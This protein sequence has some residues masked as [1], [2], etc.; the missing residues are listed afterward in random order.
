VDIDA[1]AVTPGE[2]QC[3]C[4]GSQWRMGPTIFKCF[5]F[6]SAASNDGSHVT[7]S[8]HHHVLSFWFLLLHVY[9]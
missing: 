2:W 3:G 9:A 7:L 8:Q 5:L 4:G 1:Q 6:T